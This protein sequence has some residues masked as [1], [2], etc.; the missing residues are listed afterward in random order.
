MLSEVI[1]SS[2]VALSS[3]AQAQLAGEVVV[4]HMLPQ[5]FSTEEVLVAEAAQGVGSAQMGL[6]LPLTGKQGQLQREG[7]L[8]LNG[9][10]ERHEVWK[11]LMRLSC[12][13][14]AV[15]FSSWSW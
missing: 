9:R 6:Q 8:G 5:L 10:S 3:L 11:F 1:S 2:K 14:L 13:A 7:P 12:D 4:M 15:C